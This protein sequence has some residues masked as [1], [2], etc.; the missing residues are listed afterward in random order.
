MKKNVKLKEVKA[1]TESNGEWFLKLVY[2]Y[3]DDNGKHEFTY[4]KVC[5]P[6]YQSSIPFLTT[7]TNKLSIEDFD[8]F[9]QIASFE[10]DGGCPVFRGIVVDPRTNK[11]LE[12]QCIV[13]DILVEPKVHKMTLEEIEEKLGYKVEIVSNR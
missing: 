5:L 9:I 11:P 6:F 13:A 10:F 8:N 12:M 7:T 2:T 1:Y 3:D 4:P